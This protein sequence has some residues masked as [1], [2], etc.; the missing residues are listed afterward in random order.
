LL[1]CPNDRRGT[2]T[3]LVLGLA[4]TKAN[5]AVVV[6]GVT[7]DQFKQQGAGVDGEAMICLAAF[8]IPIDQ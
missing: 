3:Q 4:H 5:H 7:V 8:D 2:A 6:A 1:H